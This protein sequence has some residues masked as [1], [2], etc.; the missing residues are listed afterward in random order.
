M[1]RIGAVIFDLD[2]VLYAEEDYIFAAYRNIAKFL[3]EKCDLSD[4]E[5]YDRL[6]RDFRRKTS[7][8][9]RL[10]NDL[11]AD[12]GLGQ[13]LVPEILGIYV[14]TIPDLKLLPGTVNVLEGLRRNRM[15]LGLLTNGSV[16]AQKN[17]V[18]L[19]GLEKYFESIVYARE[20]G[21]E[22]EKPNPEAYREVLRALHVTPEETI[23][24]GDN[25]HT[26]FWGAKK[27]GIRTVRLLN[28]E[29]K[30]IRLSSEYEADVTVRNLDEF[31]RLI[32]QSS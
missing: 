25:P 32:E 5:I 3:S 11:V 16:E 27:L 26:D 4:R 28:G 14:S 2:N 7:M 9:P 12:L 17:K 15:R 10:F 23:C 31:Y 6:V 8:Y 24:I 21:K 18:R 20:K 22:N 1:D 30:N 19:L 29:F 13:D